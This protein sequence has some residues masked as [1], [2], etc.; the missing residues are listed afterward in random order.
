MKRSYWE[1][2]ASSYQ[3]EIFDVLQQD[4]KKLLA[5]AIKKFA[6]PTYSV[7][8]IG[9]AIGKWLPVLSPLFKKVIALDISQ[10]N[11]KI[12]Q[13]LYPT[14]Q[15]VE[16]KRVDMSG[17]R[18]R[19]PAAEFGVCINAILTPHSKDRAVFFSNLKK[20][21]KKKGTLVLTVPSLESYLLTRIVQQQ[22][23]IDKRAFTEKILPKKGLEKW[24]QLTQG[25]AEI[26]QVPHKH[27]L[28]EELLLNLQRAGFNVL[29]I[30]KI[31][32]PW[33]T[34]F[35]HPPRWLQS[36]KPWDWMVV[37]QKS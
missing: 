21:I 7:I 8:D 32:Y 18:S 2:M 11:L 36:P 23:S 14:L 19:I 31:E 26:D 13:Q 37:A 6:K 22:F 35:N 9:C 16:Y 5:K 28:Q 4:K 30:K 29:E 1:N 10:N 25:V 24:R 33:D 12:A 15:N 20:C 3:E 17:A 34:E 27:F